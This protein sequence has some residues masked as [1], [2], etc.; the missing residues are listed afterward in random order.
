MLVLLGL[1]FRMVSCSWKHIIGKYCLTIHKVM[2]VDLHKAKNYVGRIFQFMMDALMPADAVNTAINTAINAI[3]YC[4]KSSL[5]TTR[6]CLLFLSNKLLILLVHYGVCTYL[7]ALKQTHQQV[8]A[9]DS[10]L[11]PVFWTTSWRG[12]RRVAALQQNL[13][14][15]P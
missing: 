1:R 14:D 10:C 8:F 13:L 7:H 11:L 12:E 5:L 2:I 15:F 3:W 9:F 4:Y 6:C